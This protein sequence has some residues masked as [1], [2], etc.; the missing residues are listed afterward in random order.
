MD[1]FLHW[2]N[3][4]EVV[5][6]NNVNLMLLAEKVNWLPEGEKFELFTY[7]DNN[8]IFVADIRELEPFI[9]SILSSPGYL[10]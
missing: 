6:H 10:T 3:L 4:S 1:Y 9:K 8:P 7:F 5:I 2:Y